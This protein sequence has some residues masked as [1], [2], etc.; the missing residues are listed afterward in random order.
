M[1][2]SPLGRSGIDVSRVC[3]GSMTWG[4]QNNQAD[5]DEQIAYA[6]DKGVNFIDT[7][8]LYPV[9]PTGEKYGDTEQII[10]NYLSANKKQRNDIV[11]ATKI[12]GNGL[13]W[14]RESAD[15]DGDAIIKSV[16]ASLKR[17][18]TDYIDLYQ[19]HWPNRHDVRHPH[20]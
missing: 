13:P 4:M 9:P 19:L 1:L 6:L 2:Y 15:I 7:A 10:G 3:L 5:A 14:I 12:A 20:M 17:L 16:D 18:Q 11:L 8:E